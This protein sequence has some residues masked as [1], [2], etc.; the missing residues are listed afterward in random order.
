[1]RLHTLCQGNKG[2][3]ECIQEFEVLTVRSEIVETPKQS[4]SRF[5]V[6]L[7]YEIENVVELQRINTFEE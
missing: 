5:I 1:M 4:I 2:I 7:Q 6:R 3:V